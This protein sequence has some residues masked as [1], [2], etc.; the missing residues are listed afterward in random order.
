MEDQPREP[1]RKIPALKLGIPLQTFTII[2]EENIHAGRA[3]TFEGL[4]ASVPQDKI[5]GVS[6]SAAH[7]GDDL[8]LVA[9]GTVIAEAGGPIQVGDAIIVDR[10]GR[11]TTLP[12]LTEFEALK[13]D[14]CVFGDALQSAEEPGD[15]LEILLRR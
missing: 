7:A 5:F 4:I 2:A 11:M 1:T 9:S 10:L 12:T 15:Y 14:C 8:D 6:T 13:Q 3:V